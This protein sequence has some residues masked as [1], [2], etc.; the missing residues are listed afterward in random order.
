MKK[1]SW[2]VALLLALT[3]TAFFIS[4]GVD[5]IE[6]PPPEE[7]F[8]SIDLGAYNQWGGDK[9]KQAGWATAGNTSNEGIV[10]K[11]LGYKLDD[12]KAATRLVLE[13]TDGGIKGGV[14][15]I[16]GGNEGDALGGWNDV[17]V[18]NNSGVPN[19]LSAKDGN[20]LIIY[21][22]KVIASKGKTSLWAANDSLKII[23]AY[24]TGKGVEELVKSAK[25][26][27]PLAMVGVD[28]IT[29]NGSKFDWQKRFD[30]ST[31][32]VT[33][34]D[35][36]NKD[37]TWEIVKWT[38]GTTTFDLSKTFTTDMARR[39]E[40]AALEK[41]VV[42]DGKSIIV[43]AGGTNAS[44]GNVTLKATIKNGKLVPASGNNPAKFEPFTKEF[45]IKI[46]EDYTVPSGG[47]GFFYLDLNQNDTQGVATDVVPEASTTS[48][49]I[50]IPFTEANQR[51]N[52]KLTPL[53]A[54]WVNSAT[55]VK[56]TIT[57]SATGT[58]DLYNYNFGD[59]TLSTNGNATDPFTAAAFSTIKA[60]K[61][62]TL[63]ANKSLET[64]GYFILNYKG[65]ASN[66]PVVTIEKIKI[67]VVGATMSTFMDA[68][69][70]KTGI[71]VQG[72]AKFDSDTGIISMGT[73]NGGS[74]LVVI[75][76]PSPTSVTGGKSIKVSYV[77][78]VIDAGDNTSPTAKVSIKDG[79]WADPPGD[80]ANPPAQYWNNISLTIDTADVI[81]V[82]ENHYANGS[83]KMSLQTSDWEDTN[84]KIFYIK[85]TNVTI[86]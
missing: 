58:T 13:L 7:E 22:D 48:T 53:Q 47:T 15:I 26:Q 76:L 86:E 11:D 52:F 80:P 21:L 60:E 64:C 36:T 68:T 59:P 42:L 20:S 32:S 37:I 75:D 50:E 31:A 78:T 85:V 39:N 12:F 29:L 34:I 70:K 69:G 33:P 63:N 5:P 71:S 84:A 38:D 8:D 72:N 79:G 19:D 18:T 3:F 30:L 57:G 41:K 23:V 62:L 17:A 49:Q 81:T 56:V 44:V 45:T 83:T 65:D 67:E 6:I 9:A 54:L 74:T 28:N 16:F 25:L 61:S 1:N 2:I 77:C 51:V 66:E 14:N 40:I 46:Q 73:G 43:P 35:A 82:S 10:A 4:C 55:S 27:I 24:Y